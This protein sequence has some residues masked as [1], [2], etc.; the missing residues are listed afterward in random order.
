MKTI[1]LGNDITRRWY[2]L[3]PETLNAHAPAWGKLPRSTFDV[4]NIPNIAPQARVS[5]DS[6]YSMVNT[7]DRNLLY[8]PFSENGSLTVPFIFEDFAN[9]R[10]K[11]LREKYRLDEIIA[12]AHTDLA[13]AV[14]LRD[15]L[16][17]R[18]DHEQPF[19]SP[20]WDAEYILDHTDKKLEGFY[21]V[22]YSVAYMQLCMSL[23]IPARLVNLHRGICTTPFEGRGYGLEMD[24]TD[25]CDEHVLNEVWL[26]DQGKWVVMDVDFDI[27]YERDGAPLNAVEIHDLLVSNSLHRLAPVEGPL[28]YKLS[29]GPDFYQYKLPHYYKHVCLFWR[30]NHLSDPEGP[31]RI[32]HWMDEHTPPILW[33]E[34]EDLRHRPQ[35][36]G[37]VGI[38]CPYTN[39][40]P[41]LTDLNVATHWASSEEAEEHWV[42]LAWDEQKNISCVQILWAKCWGHYYTSCE[43]EIQAWQDSEWRTVFAYQGQNEKMFDICEFEMI[44]TNKIRL[45]QNIHGGSSEFPERLWIAEIGVN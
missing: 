43:Y 38:S 29:A 37:P 27:H 41:V 40:T 3:V 24:E 31:T 13:R 32:L 45:V 44:V 26:G 39:S 10:L 21:C 36:I 15:W 14:L 34:G 20:P 25:P 8:F 5:V 19:V 6:F 28:A 22:H 12:P 42:E 11:R 16:K 9:P 33:W 4:E 17:A 2:D 30:N 7:S 35:I 18:W 1:F 23:G